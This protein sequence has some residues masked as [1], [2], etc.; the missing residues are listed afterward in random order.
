[1]VSGGWVVRIARRRSPARDDGVSVLVEAA[2]V[3]LSSGSAHGG[4]HGRAGIGR[5]EGSEGGVLS[6]LTLM[7]RLAV[8]HWSVCSAKTAPTRRITAR[9]L[10]KV[11]TTS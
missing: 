10:G 7:K 8:A 9:R 1:M 6:D 3:G 4:V 2:A 11:P 5:A